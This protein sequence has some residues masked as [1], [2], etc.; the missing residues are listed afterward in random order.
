LKIFSLD[1][2]LILSDTLITGQEKT[3]INTSKM[4]QGFYMLTVQKADGEVL[5]AKKIAVKR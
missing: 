3:I 1:G 4:A 2:S 5:F